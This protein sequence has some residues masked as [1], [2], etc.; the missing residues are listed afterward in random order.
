MNIS[1]I[2]NGDRILVQSGE[3]VKEVA[4]VKEILEDGMLYIRLSNGE[5]REIHPQYVLKIFR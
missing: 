3:Y 5:F 1:D 2:T 4:Q